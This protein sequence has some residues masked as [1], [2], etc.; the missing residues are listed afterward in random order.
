[1][2]ATRCCIRDMQGRNKKFGKLKINMKSDEIVTD[3]K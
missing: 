2:A 3:F 1:M